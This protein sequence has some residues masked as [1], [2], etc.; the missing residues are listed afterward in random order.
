MY[1]PWTTTSRET[2]QDPMVAPTLIACSLPNPNLPL[3]TP[4]LGS[5]SG[6][7]GLLEGKGPVHE[8]SLAGSRPSSDLQGHVLLVLQS[9]R[10]EASKKRRATQPVAN[11]CTG[12]GINSALIVRICNTGRPNNQGVIGGTCPPCWLSSLPE[13]SCASLGSFHLPQGFKDG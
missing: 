2:H 11:Q 6:C 13:L 7:W 3:L 9:R 12:R 4:T 10:E 8:R 5:F 1:R